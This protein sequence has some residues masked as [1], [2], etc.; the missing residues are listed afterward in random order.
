M[1]SP[2]LAVYRLDVPVRQRADRYG[3]IG[4]TKS[5]AG[6]RTVPLPPLV[7]AALRELRLLADGRRLRITRPGIRACAHKL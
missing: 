7:V 3:K 2:W 5:A 4:R 1:L 6:E